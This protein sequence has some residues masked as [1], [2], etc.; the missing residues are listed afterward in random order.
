MHK[1]NPA[2]RALERG[3]ACIS[4]RKRKVKCDG[5]RPACGRCSGIGRPMDCEY[6]DASGRTESE[7]LEASIANL[8]R[9]ILQLGGTLPTSPEVVL[10][11]PHVEGMPPGSS[12]SSWSSRNQNRSQD[13][14]QIQITLPDNWWKPALPPRNVVK[15]LMDLFARHASQFGFFLNG[16]RIMNSV[17]SPD[18]ARP[19]SPSLL[20]SILLFGIHLSG[21][22]PLQARETE[23]LNRAARSVAPIQP[24]QVTQNIQGEVLLAQYFLRQ[25]RFLESMHRINTAASLAIGCGLHR[26]PGPH[27]AKNA[28]ALPPTHDA[29]EQGERVNAFWMIVGL[30]KIFSVLMQWPSS[31][32]DILDEQIDLPWPLDME[33]YESGIV[34]INPHRQFTMKTFLDDPM[35]ANSEA[36]NSAPAQYAKAAALFERASHTGGNRTNLSDP[37]EYAQFILFEHGLTQIIQTLPS[38]DTVQGPIDAIRQ[39]LVTFTLCQVAVIQLHSAFDNPP[40]IVKCLN[41]ARA[42]VSVNQRIPNMQIWQYIDSTMGTLWVAVCQIIIRGIATIKNP[43][44]STRGWIASVSKA[45][46]PALKSALASMTN[47]MQIFSPRC[48]LIDYQLNRVQESYRTLCG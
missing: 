43:R 28:Y 8:E 16:P 4:C 7:H 15:I 25:G 38:P 37:E 14:P 46:Y 2:Y 18:P 22:P 45:D 21:S 23:Y 9:R 12:F 42:V 20:N 47:T 40:S 30:H 10:H 3:G 5:G 39:R 31:V 29:V 36:A 24:Y 41:A 17:F 11:E 34:P 19:I 6:I 26:L 27:S 44:G 13:E 32:S 1:S 33:V 48:P 35:A